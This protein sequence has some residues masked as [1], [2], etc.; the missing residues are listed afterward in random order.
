MGIEPTSEAWEAPIL[1]L[2]YARSLFLIVLRNW[3]SVQRFE[4]L[5]S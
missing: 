5:E 2:N 1:P 4:S 3:F